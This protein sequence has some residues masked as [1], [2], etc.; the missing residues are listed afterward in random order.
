MP[1]YHISDDFNEGESINADL[2]QLIINLFDEPINDDSDRV[3]SVAFV[4]DEN[5]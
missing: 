1:D 2:D 5:W 4:I 3:K